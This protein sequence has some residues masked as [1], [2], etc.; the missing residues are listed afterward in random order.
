M[1]LNIQKIFYVGKK[2]YA[3]SPA[4]LLEQKNMSRTNIVYLN[5][6]HIKLRLVIRFRNFTEVKSLKIILSIIY[7]HQ[8]I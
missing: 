5:V 7:N 1:R 6:T 2:K 3:A 4:G 8:Y